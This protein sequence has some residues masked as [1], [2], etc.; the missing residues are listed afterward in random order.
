MVRTLRQGLATLSG[1]SSPGK[2]Q[3]FSKRPGV[4]MKPIPNTVY[5]I[6]WA[7][8]ATATAAEKPHSYHPPRLPDGHADMEGVWKN[9][10]LTPLERPQELAQLTITAAD[11]A[12]L[13]AQYLQGTGGPN[14]PD[15]PGRGLEDRN[16]EPIRGELRSS[17]I[18]DP[19]DGKI[20]WNEAFKAKPVA[21]RRTVLNAFDNPE[22]RPTIERC[23][24][25]NGAP[26]MQP[27]LDGNIYQ[28]VQTPATTVIVSEWVHDARVIRMNGTHSPAAITSWLGDSVGWWEKDTLVIETKYF[29]AS[30]SVRLNARYIY[31]VSPQTVVIERFTRVSAN[32]LN[33]V[34][35]V[36][37]PTFYT[38]PWTGET[39]LLR[40]KDRMFEYACHEGNYSMRNILEAAR[41]NDLK[42]SSTTQPVR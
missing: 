4:K 40:T 19:R 25:S 38:Q 20:P 13:K 22:E 3:L 12:R 30:S 37:D 23:L 16:Y 8:C 18:I 42:V 41:A 32:E 39:H 5:W 14:Q 28:F 15:D 21:L 29:A 7:L 36:S 24:S 9:S 26:P 27:N 17:Q 11:A 34:F 1:P 35:T 33:Y 31:L 2:D 10:N 6:L